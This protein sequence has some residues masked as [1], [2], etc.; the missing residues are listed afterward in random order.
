MS[1][2]FPERT[3]ALPRAPTAA[4]LTEEQTEIRRQYARAR[5]YCGFTLDQLINSPSAQ[6]YFREIWLLGCMVRKP[7]KASSLPAGNPF[8]ART[9]EVSEGMGSGLPARRWPDFYDDL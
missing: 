8:R 6:R 4:A 1:S 5:E 9:R 3:P 2:L 7:H